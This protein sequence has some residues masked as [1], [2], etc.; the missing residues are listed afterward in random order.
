MPWTGIGTEISRLK[1][2][3]KESAV[4]SGKRGGVGQEEKECCDP[5][6]GDGKYPAGWMADQ[7]PRSSPIRITLIRPGIPLLRVITV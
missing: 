2:K 6:G 7:Y 3:G 5:S 4:G 1:E